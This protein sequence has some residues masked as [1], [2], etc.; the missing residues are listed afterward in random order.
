MDKF[1]TNVSQVNPLSTNPTKWSNTLKQFVG[2]LR[3]NCLS[4]F[5]H[6][7]FFLLTLFQ[8]AL[9]IAPIQNSGLINA[10][11]NNALYGT[12]IIWYNK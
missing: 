11:Y 2:K 12:I 7:F 1:G 5:D 6:F 10:K 4:V 3:K 8:F 9:A